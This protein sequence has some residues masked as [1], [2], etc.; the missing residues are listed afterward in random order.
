MSPP[1]TLLAGDLGG[2]KT[3]LALYTWD[4]THLSQAYKQRYL[5]SEWPTLQPMLENF[6]GSIPRPLPPPD[7]GCLAVAGKVE[8]SSVLITNLSWELKQEDLCG[9]AELK[10][11]ELINDF[12]VLVYGLPSLKAC[13]QEWLQKPVNGIKQEG[14]IAIIGAG[15]GLGMARGFKTQDGIISLPSE[16]GHKEFSPRCRKEWQLSEWLKEELKV[17]RLSVERIVS[18]TGLG[19][20]S[21]WLI[22]QSQ[23]QHHALTEAAKLWRD[24]SSKRPDLPSLAS[25]AAEEGD[26]LMKEALEIWLNAYGSAA[27]DLALH[28]LST[29]GIWIAGGTAYKQLKGL[30]TISFL[31][32]FC[33]KGRFQEFLKQL[34]VIAL[35]D[36]EAGLFSAACRARI[37]AQL[38]GKLT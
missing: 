2:T 34:P 16:G 18:G 12:S 19:H 17:N 29:G 22:L 3:I 7:Y 1:I 24:K 26:P 25:K 36:P 9:V 32:G 13:Q 8:R 15:T 21:C 10:Q 31:D 14:P 6:L 30:K 23:D 28:E 11:L 37:I 20:I 38:N 35:I 27:G 5:S 4:G 33:N